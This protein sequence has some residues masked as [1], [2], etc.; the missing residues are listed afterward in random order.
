MVSRAEC[1]LVRSRMSLGFFTPDQLIE[2]FGLDNTF[3]DPYS[4]LI[5]YKV[6]LGEGNVFYPNV[7]IQAGVKILRIGMGNTFF[8]G[9][10]VRAVKG[11]IS[12]GDGNQFGIGGC[13]I[14]ADN[15]KAEMVIGNGCRF[16]RGAALYGSTNLGDGAQVLGPIAVQ[17]CTL[18]GGESFRDPDPDK[19]AA[20]LKGFGTARGLQVPC[21][22]VINGKGDFHQ[23]ELERQ[24]VYHPKKLT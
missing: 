16:L 20:V 14:E 8:S 11:R 22:H 9:V 10:S 17:D 6:R 15:V 13:I 7:M 23:I 2:E 3:L 21:G 19:R 1:H 24:S 5:S 18:E 12:I 4:C